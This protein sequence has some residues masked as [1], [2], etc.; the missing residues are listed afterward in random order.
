[1]KPTAKLT[2]TDPQG[3]SPSA[4]IWERSEPAPRLAPSPLSRDSIVNAAIVIADAEGLDAVSLRRV[5]AAVDAKAMRLYGYLSTKEELLELMVDAVYADMAPRKPLPGN[6]RDALRQVA[7]RTRRTSHRHAWLLD[8]LGGRPHQ[9]PNALRFI[10]A[11]LT[12]LNGPDGFQEIDAV[13]Q[14]A[15]TFNAFLIGALRHE[16]SERRA[17]RESGLNKLQWQSANGPY[18]HK[19]I[20]TGRFP[21][22]A[23]VVLTATHPPADEVFDQGLECVLDGIAARLPHG[24]VR[25]AKK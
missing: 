5:G 11:S 8:L 1:M 19:M 4:F 10:E 3:H 2:R 17:E 15:K 23:K 9:G 13:L 22:F 21:T 25:P 24:R 7:Q 20:A 12:A 14:A 6:W 18:I 16:A